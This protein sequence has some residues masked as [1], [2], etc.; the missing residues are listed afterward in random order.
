[1]HYAFIEIGTLSSGLFPL[2]HGF[3]KVAVGGITGD[4]VQLPQGLAMLGCG[5]ITNYHIEFL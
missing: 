5:S 1:M 2:S 3:L 4:C